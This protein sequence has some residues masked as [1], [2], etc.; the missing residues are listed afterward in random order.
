MEKRTILCPEP[1]LLRFDSYE[2]QVAKGRLKTLFHQAPFSFD[3]MDQLF[4]IMNDVLDARAFPRE[5]EAFRHLRMKSRNVIL[6]ETGDK[7]VLR[8]FRKQV[9]TENVPDED[10]SVWKGSF[11]GQMTI[12]VRRRE[13]GSLQGTVNIKGEK[14]HFRSVLE[15]MYMF[16]EYLEH[17]FLPHS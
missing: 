8:S 9:R 16:H 1:M 13:Y 14:T 15:L 2:K 10:G 6:A 7:A 11:Q 5:G 17:T 12:T 4:L 3:S